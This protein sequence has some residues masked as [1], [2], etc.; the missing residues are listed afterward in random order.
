MTVLPTIIASI[1]MLFSIA[2]AVA[3]SPTASTR[4]HGSCPMSN[5]LGRR[6]APFY[7]LLQAHGEH[8][9]EQND[10]V[11]Q[12]RVMHS[13][14]SFPTSSTKQNDNVSEKYISYY[15][16]LKNG[17]VLDVL[18]MLVIFFFLA[19]IWLSDGRLINDTA[20]TAQIYKYVDA[21]KLL[22]DDFQREYSKVIF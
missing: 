5:N 15:N 20:S 18:A 19:T 22:Q 4:A 1:F 17:N 11:D 21:E 14:L 16:G 9:D 7:P 6:C 13:S 12:K 8:G 3:L 10:N 2:T